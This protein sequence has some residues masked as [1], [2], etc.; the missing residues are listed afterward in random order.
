MRSRKGTS[1]KRM[2]NEQAL[3]MS[4]WYIIVAEDRPNSQANDGEDDTEDR[5]EDVGNSQ[6]KAQDHAQHTG[7]KIESSET[8]IL[9]KSKSFRDVRGLLRGTGAHVTSRHDAFLLQRSRKS[10]ELGRSI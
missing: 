6:S 8:C 3:P 2:I 5:G 10:D 1:M 7:P 4:E 9:S